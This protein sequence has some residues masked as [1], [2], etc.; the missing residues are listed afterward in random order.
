MSIRICPWCGSEL[1]DPKECNSVGCMW[2]DGVELNMLEMGSDIN[3]AE[4][5]KKLKNSKKIGKEWKKEREI[6]KKYRK[7]QEL[8]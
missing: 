4:L 6:A 2:Y 3:R 8:D 5:L 7:E 1:E